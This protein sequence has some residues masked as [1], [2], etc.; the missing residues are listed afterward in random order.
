VRMPCAAV[1]PICALTIL[2]D[3][4][5][6]SVTKRLVADQEFCVVS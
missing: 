5:L 3:Y 4:T 1:T 2:P 6:P